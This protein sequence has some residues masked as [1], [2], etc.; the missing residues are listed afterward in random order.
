[1]FPAVL[2]DFIFKRK[3]GRPTAPL[4]PFAAEPLH[5]G[6]Q[7]V[8]VSIN[9]NTKYSVS[10]RQNLSKTN[11]H[12]DIEMRSCL[13]ESKFCLSLSLDLNVGSI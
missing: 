6:D 13:V 12:T 4:S 11:V 3:D 8:C 9:N 7:S 10:T 2:D 1:M 5:L